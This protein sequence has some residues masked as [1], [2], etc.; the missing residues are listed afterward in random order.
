[1]RL[2]L[3]S[4]AVTH[5]AA[6]RSISRCA[7]PHALFS[8]LLLARRELEERL[9]AY[10]FDDMIDYEGDEGDEGDDEGSEGDGGNA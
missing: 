8:R 6:R 1:M 3:L 4:R 10:L 9:L 2:S 5:T 7:R